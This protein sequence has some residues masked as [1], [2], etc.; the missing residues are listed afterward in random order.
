[1]DTYSYVF[2][3]V[4]R[5]K[6]DLYIR[7]SKYM[8]IKIHTLSPLANPAGCALHLRPLPLQKF[9]AREASLPSQP[10]F[11]NFPSAAPEEA[12]LWSGASLNSPQFG[13]ELLALLSTICLSCHTSYREE[14]HPARWSRRE[15]E[16]LTELA[17]TSFLTTSSHKE[18]NNRFCHWC[19]ISWRANSYCC[20]GTVC[21]YWH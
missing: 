16:I 3:D 18:W 12:P 2:L 21:Q 5:S 8:Q 20:N 4:F 6:K 15:E 19:L 9:K 1:M 13:S 11:L 14:R 17:D 10:K 7:M